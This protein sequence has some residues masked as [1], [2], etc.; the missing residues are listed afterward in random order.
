MRIF[1][2]GEPYKLKTLKDTFGEKFYMPNGVNGIIDNVGYYH[3]IKNEVIYLL[4]KVFI[5][6]KGLL[7]KNI[8]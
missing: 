8:R 1:I 6:T 3:S 7:L 2:E 5:D 4:P